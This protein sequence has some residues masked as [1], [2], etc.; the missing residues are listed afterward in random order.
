[1][2]S[3]LSLLPKNNYPLKILDGG[4]GTGRL[5]VELAKIGHQVTGIDI[6]VPAME[7]AKERAAAAGVSIEY[8]LGDLYE[9]IKKLPSDYFDAGI[10]VGVL[11]TCAH[12]R[13]IIKEF[14]RVIKKDGFL[15][16]N[17]CSRFYFVSTFLRQK[18]FVNALYVKNHSE[19]LLK[20][21]KVPTYYNWHSEEDVRAL[22]KENDLKIL[23]IRAVGLFSGQGAD[24]LAAILDVDDIPGDI[25]DSPL[26]EL[27]STEWQ[28]CIS[29]GRFIMAIGQVV[30]N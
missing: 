2:V 26:Y 3:Q 19:G 12:Y 24:G 11:Y 5:T 4:S 7:E 29:A 13:E 28:G 17:F 27:E 22:Y 21:Y 14:C 25:L 6:N 9:S 20:L 8:I 15:L 16:A 1:M 10:C 30:K 23:K 18:N